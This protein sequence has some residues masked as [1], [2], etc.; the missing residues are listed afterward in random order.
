MVIDIISRLVILYI[1]TLVLSCAGHWRRDARRPSERQDA[2]AADGLALDGSA[3]ARH[4]TYSARNTSSLIFVTDNWGKCVLINLNFWFYYWTFIWSKI[5][6]HPISIVL[7]ELA[8]QML[9]CQGSWGRRCSPCTLSGTASPASS[10]SSTCSECE[11]NCETDTSLE[12]FFLSIPVSDEDTDIFIALRRRLCE[13][14][15]CH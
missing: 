5:F 14:Y 3:H 13:L 15:D 11:L 7:L 9:R 10:G 12:S 4:S 8:E 1:E 2:A 6:F